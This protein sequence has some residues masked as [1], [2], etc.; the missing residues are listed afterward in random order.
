MIDAEG[1]RSNV[2]IILCN[3][4]QKVLW[5]RRVGQN[6]WQFPQGGIESYEDP[7]DAMYR[8]LHEEIGLDAHHVE[9]LGRTED[10]LR[11]EIPKRYLRRTMPLCIGQKQIWFLLKMLGTDDDICFDRSKKAEFDAC[12]WVDYWQPASHIVDFKREV[13]RAALSELEYL[14]E[15]INP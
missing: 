7:E 2:G 3:S 13:Y 10:W 11:Y 5:A 4:E 1:Y 6:T 8:E 9:V 14:L 12:E 15:H